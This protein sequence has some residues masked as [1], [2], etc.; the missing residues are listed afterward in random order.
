MTYIGPIWNI[1][2]LFIY[3]FIL[4]LQ[5]KDFIKNQAIELFQSNKMEGDQIKVITQQNPNHTMR[6]EKMTYIID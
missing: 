4:L 1:L 3:L 6:V 5:K 2:F